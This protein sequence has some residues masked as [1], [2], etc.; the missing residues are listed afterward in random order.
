MNFINLF[1]QFIDYIDTNIPNGS[2]LSIVSFIFCFLVFF[3]M[4]FLKRMIE[5]KTR[6]RIHKIEMELCKIDPKEEFKRSTLL[7]REKNQ[8]QK[9]I[10]PFQLNIFSEL[11]IYF[12]I[13]LLLSKK[14]VC[15]FPKSFW[16]PIS[17]YV[18]L[19]CKNG[20]VKVWFCYYWSLLAK[21][22]EK[23]IKY[24]DETI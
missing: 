17:G 9:K 7:T 4:L 10:V 24:L 6:A 19:V 8:L 15:N 22:F 20:I 12:V 2:E 21:T 23:W 13:P 16:V 3:S 14:Y 1:H 11:I 5:Y 18:S